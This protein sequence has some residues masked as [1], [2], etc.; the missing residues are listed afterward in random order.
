MRTETLHIQRNPGAA[1]MIF[2]QGD[3]VQEIDTEKGISRLQDPRVISSILSAKFGP[4]ATIIVIGPSSRREGPFSCYDHFFDN[5]E[6]DP[7]EGTY[8]TQNFKASVHLQHLLQHDILAPHI[9]HI[10]VVGFSKG[11]IILNQVIY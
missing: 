3:L 2:F 5:L 9:Q 6:G 11:G 10:D 8:R 4:E 7:S 1:L